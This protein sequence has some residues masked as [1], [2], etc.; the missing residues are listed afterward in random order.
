MKQGTR[1]KWLPLWAV[2]ALALALVCTALCLLALY[3]PALL[4]APLAAAASPAPTAAPSPEPTAEPTPRPTPEPTPTP[5]PTP[6]P[7][8]TPTPWDVRFAEHFSAETIRDESRYSSPTLAIEMHTYSH[9]EAYPDLTY[10]VADLYLTDVHQLRTAFAEDVGATYAS[11]ASIA[12]NAGALVA[13]NGDTLANH[14]QGFVV[15]NGVELYAVDSLFDICVL[16]EDGRMEALPPYTYA[17]RDV[18]DAGAYQVWEFGPSLL[19]ADGQPLESFNADQSLFPR[20]P[21][22]VLGYYEPGHYCFV[23]ID[24]R[25]APYSAGADLPTTA[26]IMADLGCRMAYNL[27]GGASATMYFNGG[28]INIPI[29]DRYLNDMVLVRDLS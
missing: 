28:V 15:R 10:F 20:H 21:R 8:P 2:L 7:E 3:R 19:D 9:P 6:T 1:N 22:T 25:N 27:D 26:Q 4:P 23:V 11:A 17:F 18:L 16:Y 5:S 24:G 12:S 13:I 29:G 14:R